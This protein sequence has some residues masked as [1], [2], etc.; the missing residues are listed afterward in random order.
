MSARPG[1]RSRTDTGSA[2]G[3][4]QKRMVVTGAPLESHWTEERSTANHSSTPAT[5]PPSDPTVTFLAPR[6]DREQ[7]DVEAALVGLHLDE[8]SSVSRSRR[9]PQESI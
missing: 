3:P 6:V 4:C 1:S 2:S 7:V 8:T 5:S 9:P